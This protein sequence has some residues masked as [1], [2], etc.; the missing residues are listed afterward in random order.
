[1]TVLRQVTSG[2]LSIADIEIVDPTLDD[3]YAH[4]LY[5]E[6]AE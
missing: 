4:F 1:V 3:I 6:A 5:A 2:D